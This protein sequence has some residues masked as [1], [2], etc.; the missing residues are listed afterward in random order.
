MIARIMLSMKKAADAP[1][2]DW[3]FMGQPSYAT[4]ARALNFFRPRRVTTDRGDD[5]RLDTFTGS[6]VMTQEM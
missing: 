3:S 5:M 1:R 6:P 2:N 4:E